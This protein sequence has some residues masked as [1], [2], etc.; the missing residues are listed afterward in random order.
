MVMVARGC[1]FSGGLCV[2]L[3][4]VLLPSAFLAGTTVAASVILFLLPRWASTH[5]QT[6]VCHH[7]EEHVDVRGCAG[8]HSLG[9]AGL[10]RVRAPWAGLGGGPP[11]SPGPHPGVPAQP[12]PAPR[13][14]DRAGVGSRS[15]RLKLRGRP[16][17]RAGDVPLV[18]ARALRA[19]AESPCPGPLPATEPA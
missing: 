4:C 10:S 17:L 16:S 6:K 2:R 18:R 14:Q 3:R 15:D 9:P 1:S 8:P 12:S 13:P 11:G 5:L 7:A 19:F